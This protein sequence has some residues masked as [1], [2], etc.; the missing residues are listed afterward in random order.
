VL[1]SH[2]LL[3]PHEDRVV[4]VGSIARGQE[5]KLS[6]CGGLSTVVLDEYANKGLMEYFIEAVRWR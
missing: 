6:A 1:P 4:K 3:G 2:H 5:R